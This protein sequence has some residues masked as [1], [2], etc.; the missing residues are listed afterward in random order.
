MKNLLTLAACLLLSGASMADQGPAL[1]T[2][3]PAEG[4]IV[5][6]EVPANAAWQL[7]QRTAE[8][9]AALEA[10]MGM[11]EDDEAL[12]LQIIDLKRQSD[13]QRLELLATDYRNQ[14]R[15]EEAAEAEAEL[16]RR[17]TPNQ[18]REAAGRVPLTL[19]QKQ[20]I[21]GTE[22]TAPKA[23]VSVPTTSTT[24]GGAQ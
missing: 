10:R 4:P 23:A 15:L 16:Q 20:A 24:D 22:S 19:E 18:D 14:G 21:G 9:I 17:L 3:G 8:S 11:G 7:Q 13:L 6:G 12:Q 2:S 1:V 5:R